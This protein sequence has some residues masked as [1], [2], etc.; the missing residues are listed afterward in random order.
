MHNY[1]NNHITKHYDHIATVNGRIR[2]SC[3]RGSCNNFPVNIFLGE[4]RGE[5]ADAHGTDAEGV[6]S[7]P[8]VGERGRVDPAAEGRTIGL[9][10]SGKPSRG[11][12]PSRVGRGVNPRPTREGLV[13]CIF[14]DQCG[15]GQEHLFM[16]CYINGGTGKRGT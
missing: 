3:C 7:S 8:W 15:R 16:Y 14:G 2:K 11:G 1:I 4:L 13:E 6:R 12:K 5:R 10:D 9:A